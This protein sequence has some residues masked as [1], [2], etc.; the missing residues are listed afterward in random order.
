MEGARGA[1]LTY[2]LLNG[3]TSL[4]DLSV[5]LIDLE[6]AGLPAGYY[7]DVLRRLPSITAAQVQQAARALLHP[8]ALLWV[9]A[10]EPAV[11]QAELA[12]AGITDARF[13]AAEEL[14]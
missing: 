13:F 6:A 4:Q 11:V 2:N 5:Q 7:A 1:L 9:V 8:E 10:G 3:L 14:R 12:E